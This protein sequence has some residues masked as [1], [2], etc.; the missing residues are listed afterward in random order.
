[1]A[2]EE[3]TKMMQRIVTMVDKFMLAN[4]FVWRED[5]DAAQLAADLQFVLFDFYDDNGS[6]SSYDPNAP[7]ADE[8]TGSASLSLG[9]QD[10]FASESVEQM[11]EDEQ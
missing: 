2:D 6:D 9:S 7:V 11:D 4:G 1:M 10:S 3:S 8:H 5:K